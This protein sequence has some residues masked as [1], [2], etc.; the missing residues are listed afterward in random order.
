MKDKP[1]MQKVAIN[2]LKELGL[3]QAA[4]N[5]ETT[6]EFDR[7]VAIAYEHFR[8]VTPEKFEAF[9]DKL[10]KETWKSRGSYDG[11]GTYDRLAF[12][13]LENYNTIP[14]KEVLLSL[15]KA[16]ELQCFDYFEIAKIE[17]VEVRPD[18]IMFGRINGC[19]DK[20]YVDQWDTDVKIEQIL[21]SNE[22]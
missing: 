13:K 22:G 1:C 9:N 21:N 11:G 3:S 7:K 10:R 15:K 6:M 8:Y 19:I 20:F 18:P 2:E 12:I 16:K 4:K 5:A 17:S 14:P